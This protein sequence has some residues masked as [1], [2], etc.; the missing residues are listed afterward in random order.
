MVLVNS[1]L[2]VDLFAEA[3]ASRVHGRISSGFGG[4]TDFVAGALHSPGGMA[5][6]R[7]R[8]GTRR[9]MYPLWY[10]D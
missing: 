3:N 1:A 8:P 6:S 7:C 5:I 10:P 4:R 2:Q 9:R